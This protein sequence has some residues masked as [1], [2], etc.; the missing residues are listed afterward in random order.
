MDWKGCFIL[1]LILSSIG[2]IEQ[3]IK[4]KGYEKIDLGGEN[5]KA[6]IILIPK[7]FRD[8]E[9]RIPKERLEKA[10]VNVTVA[11]LES[12]TAR[13]MLG[14]T[15][16]PD[17]LLDEVDISNYDVLI[18]PGGSGSVRYL[19]NNRRVLDMVKEAYSEGKIIAAI[20]LSGAVLAN[21][22]I[23]EGKNA[24]VFPTSDSVR[25]LKE[26]GANYI[27]KGVVVDGRIITAKGPDYAD[28]FAYTILKKLS[29]L[30]KK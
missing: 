7:D 27:D 12:G 25:I 24:T 6:L 5:M 29:E 10:G 16:Q 19:W 4:E 28:E 3:H 8:E 23:L 20:C 22:G 13:G 18:I 15:A 2:C 26:K 9:F 1:L 30:S 14:M 11:G 21:S 17:V